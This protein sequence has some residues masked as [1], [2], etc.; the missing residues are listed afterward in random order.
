MLILKMWILVCWHSFCVHTEQICGTSDSMFKRQGQ[1]LFL[2]LAFWTD[3][4]IHQ[5]EWSNDD[6]TNTTHYCS[7]EESMIGQMIIL[8]TLGHLTWTPQTC[9]QFMNSTHCIQ[10]AWACKLTRSVSD[11]LWTQTAE[12]IFGWVTQLYNTIFSVS[13]TERP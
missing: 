13:Y 10:N 9:Y 4:M 8:N 5:H 7:Y 12:S 6:E 3:V 2:A 1:P 11:R